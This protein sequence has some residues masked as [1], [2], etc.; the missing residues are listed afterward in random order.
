MLLMYDEKVNGSVGFPLRRFRQL[1]QNRCVGPK[2][3]V[4]SIS[5]LAL[6]KY[7]CDS[8]MAGDA[9]QGASLLMQPSTA[10][11]KATSNR[12][13]LIVGLLMVG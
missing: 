9:T 4:C 6:A 2:S 11:C 13:V 5:S 1:T 7:P 10:L 3:C 12:V 8:W